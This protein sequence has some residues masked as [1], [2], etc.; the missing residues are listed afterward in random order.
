MYQEWF[1][2]DNKQGIHMRININMHNKN[3]KIYIHVKML[4]CLLKQTED[5]LP[6]LHQRSRLMAKSM[7]AKMNYLYMIYI[8]EVGK[9]SLNH[10]TF[11]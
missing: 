5:I 3:I 11:S 1:M 7:N 4:F 9:V 2:V 8:C 10:L 6:I